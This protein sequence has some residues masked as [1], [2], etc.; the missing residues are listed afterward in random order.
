MRVHSIEGCGDGRRVIDLALH[1]HLPTHTVGDA[2]GERRVKRH[3]PSRTRSSVQRSVVVTCV[4]LLLYKT[5]TVAYSFEADM[6]G[7]TSVASPNF[8]C[9]LCMPL[10]HRPWSAALRC[11]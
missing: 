4:F 7:A 1:F 6:F 3:T 5:G 10:S 11:T 9:C 2:D 8:S